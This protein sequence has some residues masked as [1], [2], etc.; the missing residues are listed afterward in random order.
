MSPTMRVHRALLEAGE[1]P[2]VH[3]QQR[4]GR[5]GAVRSL[6]MDQNSVR[7]PVVL[8]SSGIS[9]DGSYVT[10]GTQR[11][12]SLSVGLRITGVGQLICSQV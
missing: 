12:L 11:P 4:P 7:R 1:S 5:A 6:R 10:Y 8:P 9:R 2:D 3:G